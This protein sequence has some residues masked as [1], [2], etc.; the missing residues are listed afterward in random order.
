M[1]WPCIGGIMATLEV[2]RPRRVG[3]EDESVSAEENKA[4]FRRYVE[5]ITN[6]GNFDLADEI[7][8]HYL[9][10]QPDGSVVER[11][12]EDVKQFQAEFR[13]AFLEIHATIEDQI[14]EGDKVVSR[15]KMRGIHGGEF[16]GIAPTGEEIEL[17]GIGIF[18]FS[19]EGK[20]VE[21]WDSY[22]QLNLMRRGLE[23][24]LRVARRIQQALLPKEEPALVGWEVT[25]YYQPA[26]EVGGDFYDFLELEDGRL[27][28][29]VGDA[30][31]KGVPAALVMANTQSVLR[32]VA[33]RGSSAPGRAL[34]EANEVLYTYI[35]P[36]MFV[37]CFY[38]ILDPKSGRLLYANAGHNLPCCR[39]RDGL[40]DELRARGMPLGLMPGMSY[41]EREA[42]LS[43]E[44]CVL[45]YSDGLVEAHDS[46]GEMFGSPRLRSLLAEQ[47]GNGKALTAYLLEELERF[48][49]EEGEQEDDITLVTLRHSTIRA[50]P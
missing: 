42:V 10:H 8:D 14:A 35:P 40:V 2:D 11:G 4:I 33:Q 32:A 49:D 47:A 24:E 22:D 18:R 34:E 28:L 29:V 23:Q 45:F 46:R 5:E 41:E 39:R 17:N 20:V 48:V 43:P 21:S 15:W 38:G 3:K 1:R 27:G 9:A 16:R 44:E 31:G 26:K 19:P 7:F 13:S 30:T 50:E 36:S 25:A 6:R 12:P 37:T